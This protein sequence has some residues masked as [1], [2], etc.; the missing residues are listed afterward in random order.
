MEL[1]PSVMIMVPGE[2][3]WYPYYQ[4]THFIV[5]NNT[6]LYNDFN[7]NNNEEED[8]NLFL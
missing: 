6:H 4:Y 2:L 5:R 1:S 3:V 8:S 7:I